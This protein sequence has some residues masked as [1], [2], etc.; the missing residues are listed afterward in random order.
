MGIGVN[1][2]DTSVVTNVIGGSMKANAVDITANE[3]RNIAQTAVSAGV[4]GIAGSATVMV[5]NIGSKVSDKYGLTS[6]ETFDQNGETTTVK[7]V[8]TNK[9]Q[10]DISGAFTK[11]NESAAA[12][13]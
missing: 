3:N 8:M 6:A 4:G 5:T 2:I 10:A 1:T 7:D 12:L 11:A 9:Q 13:W